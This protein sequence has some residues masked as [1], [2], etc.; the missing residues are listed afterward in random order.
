MIETYIYAPVRGGGIE[1]LERAN[2]FGV[3]AA[4]GLKDACCAIAAKGA[5]LS[6]VA[7]LADLLAGAAAAREGCVVLLLQNK[8]LW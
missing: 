2:S 7:R 8:E 4:R 3:G 1:A 6:V 5:A